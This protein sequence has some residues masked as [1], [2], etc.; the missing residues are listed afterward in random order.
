[1]N[2]HKKR[3][4]K[5]NQMQKLRSQQQKKP[6]E[7]VKSPELARGTEKRLAHLAPEDTVTYQPI[8]G[9]LPMQLPKKII[10]DQKQ[11]YAF[12]GITCW[13]RDFIVWFKFKV[14]RMK[15]VSFPRDCIGCKGPKNCNRLK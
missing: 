9:K 7:S 5:L 12:W 13:I 3:I 10:V 6:T 8:G 2:A 11:G 15:K 4:N 1:M 14:L